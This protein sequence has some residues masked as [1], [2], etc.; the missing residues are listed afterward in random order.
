MS[1]VTSEIVKVFGHGVMYDSS[2]YCGPKR[3]S[4]RAAS[5]RLFKNVN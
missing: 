1:A 3:T 5:G 2:P 4:E